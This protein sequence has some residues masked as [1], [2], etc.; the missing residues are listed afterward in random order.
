MKKAIVILNLLLILALAC[1]AGYFAFRARALDY[2]RDCLADDKAAFLVE[3]SRLE[4][5][6]AELEAKLGG[7]LEEKAALG[8][9][10]VA[11][12]KACEALR[13][14]VSRAVEERDR[15]ALDLAAERRARA[16]AEKRAVARAELDRREREARSP[17]RVEQ[18]RPLDP[19]KREK[20]DATS[21]NELLELTTPAGA[22]AKEGGGDDS[23]RRKSNQPNK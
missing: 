8:R 17:L 12:M 19:E 1:A 10:L 21:L 15:A 11:A 13:A 6:C 3:R 18:L 16:A 5:S 22:G 23:G 2:E 4:V 7:A 14:D 20:S 9:N